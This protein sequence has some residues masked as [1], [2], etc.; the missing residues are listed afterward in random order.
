MGINCAFRAQ[1]KKS[2]CRSLRTAAW[3]SFIR[4]YFGVT[5]GVQLSAMAQVM[6][7]SQ[8]GFPRDG[9]IAGELRDVGFGGLPAQPAQEI[10]LA[11]ESLGEATGEFIGGRRIGTL[12]GLQQE[13][14]FFETTFREG[15][16]NRALEFVKIDGFG[17]DEVGSFRAL[18]GADLIAQV[19]RAGDHDDRNMGGA[20]FELGQ[21]ILPALAGFQHLIQDDEV[22]PAALQSPER[23]AGG[24]GADQPEAAERAGIEPQLLRVIFHD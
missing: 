5:S 2:W 19:H 17:E 3:L 16:F 23:D 10:M 22:R 9:V 15:D 1:L 14:G 7:I 4:P 13:D 18:Q 24:A 12:Q 11:G 6:Q 21:E 8:N 20:A